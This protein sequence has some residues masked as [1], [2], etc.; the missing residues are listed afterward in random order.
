M[1]ARFSG[2]SKE[3]VGGNVHTNLANTRR[4]VNAGLVLGQRRERWNNIKAVLAQRLV[5]VGNTSESPGNTI[6][7]YQLLDCGY[8]DTKTKFYL[9]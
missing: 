4:W 7:W 8:R 3:S 2:R 6:D 1:L 9:A 5:F